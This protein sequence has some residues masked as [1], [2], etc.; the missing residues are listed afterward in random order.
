MAIAFNLPPAPSVPLLDGL[1]NS[2]S[3]EWYRFF[4]GVFQSV[5]SG[6][7]PVPL[8]DLSGLFAAQRLTL[9]VPSW[10]FVTGSPV[11][12]GSGINGSLVIASAGASANTVLAAPSGGAGALSPRLLVGADL[13]N[14]SA[15]VLGGVR[16][17]VAVSHNF[18]TSISTSGQPVA[19]QPAS[20]DLSDTTA[21]TTYSPTDLSGASLTFTG[22]SVRYSKIGNLVSVYGTLT[23]PATADATDAQISLPVAVPNQSYATVPG[24][25]L[26]TG[27]PGSSIVAV[28]NSS[29][30]IF[31]GAAARLKNVDLSGKVLAFFLTYP[32]S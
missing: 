6:Q 10:L 24:S 19:A 2:I 8:G 22:V 27:V 23:Y 31:Q 17:L 20:T 4:A 7:A 21:P 18:L 29:A 12:G 32:A 28:A 16:S 1:Q 11:G 30:A 5:G 14:P 3:Q 25:L 15:S 26:L 9:V 13:P